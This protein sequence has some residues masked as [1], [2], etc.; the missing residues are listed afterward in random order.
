MFQA[1]V[2]HEQIDSEFGKMLVFPEEGL[3]SENIILNFC[4]QALFVLVVLIVRIYLCAQMESF[5][6][7]FYMSNKFNFNFDL[8]NFGNRN[9]SIV[10][11][12]AFATTAAI[13]CGFDNDSYGLRSR[14]HDWIF[15][16]NSYY[17]KIIP[18]ISQPLPSYY[19]RNELF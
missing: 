5:D 17:I 4:K 1:R 10:V 8:H 12:N 7:P 6:K 16:H 9:R 14:V 19:I 2:K 13:S 18:E 15:Y 11:N 3:V